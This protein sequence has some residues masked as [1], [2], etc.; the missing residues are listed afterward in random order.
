MDDMMAQFFGGGGGGMMGGGGGR[1]RR[2]KGRD[3]GHALPVTLES[4]YN[5]KSMELERE[6]TILCP[7]CKGRGTNKPG[8][9]S[10]CAACRGQGARIVVR[11][12]GPMMQQMQVPCDACSGRGTKVEAKDKCNDCKGECTKTSQSPL[13]I[14]IEKGMEHQ[15]QIPFRGE[16]DQHPDIDVPGD[17]V[18][19]LQQV[20]HDKFVRD[21]SDLHMKQKITLAEALCGFQFV[22]THLDGRQL[23]VRSTPG[24][25]VK[26]GDKKCL[27]GEGM[28]VWKQPTKFGDLVIEFDV[29]FP[30][31]MESGQI[32]VLRKN[33]PPPKS[34][35]V[36]YDASEAHD[37]FLHRQALDELR[38]E[39]EKDEDDDDDA[40]GGGGG[41]Q[42]M[43][44]AHQ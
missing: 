42:P 33:L 2:R 32:E 30:E 27:P 9:N 1:P 28:P 18:I 15:Q 43:Q 20:K 31:R 8:L 4:L 10:K 29:V 40:R 26:P 21:D 3:V 38:K 44:C 41:G 17:I 14:L 36:E 19:V 24:M 5:G 7:T 37:C 22:V 39:M 6:K 34:L 35:D 11:Q 13:K 12:M 25:I 23:V 16:G